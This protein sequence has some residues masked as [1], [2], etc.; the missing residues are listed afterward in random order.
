LKPPLPGST[1]PTTAR[2]GGAQTRVKLGVFE[3]YLRHFARASSSAIDR[4]YVDGLP[5][6][7]EGIDKATGDR[8]LRFCLITLSSNMARGA[9]SE[10]TGELDLP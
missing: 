1:F 2:P 3:G 4:I 9:G 10:L 6:S 8:H 5:G 7:G